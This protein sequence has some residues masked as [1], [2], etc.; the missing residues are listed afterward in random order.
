M[1]QFL[2]RISFTITQS[3]L[4]FT[5]QAAV[6]PVNCWHCLAS[7]YV[8]KQVEDVMDFKNDPAMVQIEG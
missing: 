7:F 5:S 2:Y 4:S 3:I 8:V 1:Q 6:I